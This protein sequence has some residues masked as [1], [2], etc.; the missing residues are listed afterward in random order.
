MYAMATCLGLGGSLALTHALEQPTLVSMGWWTAARI[1]MIGTT[2]LT[3]TLLLA[4]VVLIGWRFRQ[5]RRIL[6]TFA[7]FL[8][9]IAIS[10]IPIAWTTIAQRTDLLSSESEVSLQSD[11]SSINLV[12]DLKLIFGKLRK[13]TAFPFPMPSKL[14][15]LFYQIYTVALWCLLGIAL[16]NWKRFSKIRWVLLWAVIPSICNLLA[17][18][19][20]FAT[21]RYILFVLPYFLILVAAG[22]VTVWRWR[23][24]VAIALAL[25]YIP[26]VCGGLFRYYTVQDRQDWRGMM[27]AISAGER[28]GDRIILATHNPRKAPLALLHYYHGNNSISGLTSDTCRDA[29]SLSKVQSTSS[30]IWLICGS[31]INTSRL[32]QQLQSQFQIASHQQFTNW[33]FDRQNDYLHLFLL[34]RRSNLY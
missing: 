25:I 31:D 17:D 26:A 24:T 22:F 1:L 27:H 20:L 33:G 5:Q 34:V 9:V 16:V 19:G 10:F 4:D 21:D 8:L 32:Q 14:I 12:S 7:L 18:E 2:P 13:F 3:A 15:G 6:R 11:T 30:R 23:R 28:A 29:S